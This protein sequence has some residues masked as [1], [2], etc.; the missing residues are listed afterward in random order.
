[1]TLIV[2]GVALSWA[3]K[4]SWRIESW[5]ERQENRIKAFGIRQVSKNGK[6]NR[7][8]VFSLLKLGLA[9]VAFFAPPRIEVDKKSSAFGRVGPKPNDQFALLLHVK[10]INESQQPVPLR[11]LEVQFAGAWHKPQDIVPDSLHLSVKDGMHSFGALRR[12]AI[13]MGQ[14]IPAANMMEGKTFYHLPEPEEPCPTILDFRVRA[15]FPRMRRREIDLTLKHK[16]N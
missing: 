16:A 10:F 13:R 3:G 1:L 15:V 9:V 7:V 2:V 11:S 5:S 8:I 6:I 4:L 12:Q 14:G